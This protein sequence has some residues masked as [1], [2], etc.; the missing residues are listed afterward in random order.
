[1]ILNLSCVLIGENGNIFN[2]M[3][4]ASRTL[5]ENGLDEQAA[6]MR[7]RIMGGECGSYYDALG[8]ISEYVNITGPEEADTMKMEGFG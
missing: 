1:M 2:L 7:E 3:G 4:I 6:E 8:V 5:R